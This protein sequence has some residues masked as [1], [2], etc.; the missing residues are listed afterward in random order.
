MEPTIVLTATSGS[1]KIVT[2]LYGP[3]DDARI[4]REQAMT[5]YRAEQMN[6]DRPARVERRPRLVPRALHYDDAFIVP[7]AFE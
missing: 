2:T 5:Q 3:A 1:V 4:A 7:D 6:S